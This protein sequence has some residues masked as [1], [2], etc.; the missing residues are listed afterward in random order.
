[1]E[2]LDSYE[3]EELY[4]GGLY[5]QHPGNLRYPP[6]LAKSYNNIADP[7][8]IMRHATVLCLVG[9]CYRGGWI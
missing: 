5:Y 6:T 9:M 2:G 7:A 1:M 3:R 4:F 8:D